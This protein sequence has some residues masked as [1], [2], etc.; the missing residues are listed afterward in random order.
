[1]VLLPVVTAV[2]LAIPS[3]SSTDSPV[4]SGITIKPTSCEVLTRV[5]FGRE[6]VV[7]HSVEFRAVLN[8]PKDGPPA[9]SQGMSIIELRDGEGN[10]LVE[11]EPPERGARE[12]PNASLAA[13]MLSGARRTRSE[14]V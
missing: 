10:N 14:S 1:M 13:M 2:A 12:W 6:N 11:G 9:L 7:S 5:T 8:L 4:D 3:P